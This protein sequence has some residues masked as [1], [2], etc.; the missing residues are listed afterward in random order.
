MHISWVVVHKNP[1]SSAW[2]VCWIP[3]TESSQVGWEEYEPWTNNTELVSHFGNTE[4]F[5]GR[6]SEM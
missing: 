4:Q 1:Y 6:K 3:N 5:D 2:I